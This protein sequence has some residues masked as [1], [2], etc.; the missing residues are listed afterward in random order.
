MNVREGRERCRSLTRERDAAPAHMA[1]G[2]RDSDRWNLVGD[3]QLTNL[4]E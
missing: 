2:L 3:K 1:Q 4:Q